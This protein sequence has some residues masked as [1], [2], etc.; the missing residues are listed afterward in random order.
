MSS[1]PWR[2][3]KVMSCFLNEITV[4]STVLAS[5]SHSSLLI[6]ATVLASIPFDR[7]SDER[8]RKSGKHFDHAGA[9]VQKHL[10]DD[11][12]NPAVRI[13]HRHGIRLAGTAE[14]GA[15]V[16]LLHQLPQ[17][18]VHDD[19]VFEPRSD[20]RAMARGGK[21]RSLSTQAEPPHFTSTR[22]LI[23][24]FVPTIVV[25]LIAATVGFSFWAPAGAAT[26][27]S[28]TGTVVA[29]SNSAPL[30]GIC[31][32][33]LQTGGQIGSGDAT[34]ASDG[35]YTVTGLPAG[36]Y[37]VSFTSDAGCGNT[38][39][40]EPQWYNEQSS[41]G[42][43]TPVTVTAGATTSNVNGSL[44]LVGTI[45]GT[46]TAAQGG[47]ALSGICV[48]ATESSGPG[49]GFTQ[50]ASDG[51]YSITGL[52]TGSYTVEFS[53]NGCGNSSN[54]LPQWYNGASSASAAT[55]V[56]V[57]AGSTTPSINAAMVAGGAIS[58]TVTASVG[59]AQIGGICVSVF[60]SGSTIGTATTTSNGSY[61]V[62]EL[63]S[64]SYTV[65]FA[66]GCG[67]VGSYLPQ[68]Y[69][70]QSSAGSANS[71]SVTD[72]STTSGI[73]GSLLPGGIVTG[74]VTAAVGGA[75]LQGICV[76]ASQTG[77]SG[78]GSA[79]TAANGTYTVDNLPTGTYTV[80]F[81]AGSCGNTG[82][83]AD[84]W[85]NSESSAAAANPVSVT[86]GSTT[87]SINAA[88]E[89]GATIEGTVTA[90]NGGADLSGIC[91]FAT[92]SGG[93]TPV[94]ASTGSNGAYSIT[95]LAAGSYTVEFT[96]ACG[97]SGSYADQWYNNAS[98]QSSATTVVV[99][100]GATATGINAAMVL[101]GSISGTVT[102]SGGG[103]LY[104]TCVTATE[105][106]GGAGYGSS[107]TSPSGAYTI[108]DLPA[109]TYTVDF[110]YCGSSGTYA[111]QWYNDES[112]SG[113]ANPVTVTAGA[114][115]PNI[116]AAMVLISLPGAPT[117]VAAT[118]AN[119]SAVV[120][121]AAPSSNGG[122]AISS[123]TVT[124]ADSTTPAT[125]AQTCTW[126]S[127]PLTCT[128][129][130]LTNGDSYTFTVTATNGVGT[131]PASAASELDHPD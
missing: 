78:T 122:S 19:V 3:I 34:T 84:Q 117:S 109:G 17:L 6:L 36:T 43:A 128:V 79:T 125:A 107:L 58:G 5:I 20:Q 4:S 62:G 81:S 18:D 63:P 65:E 104:L 86:A 28:I 103:G 97:N 113:A 8:L 54:L 50:T 114:T 12:G 56:A 108:G 68:W 45:T 130:G 66:P 37:T 124:A 55:G 35:T 131:G 111:E 92:I 11:R 110:Q 2:A 90:A 27:G 10:H 119:A 49:F 94:F 91:V 121:W 93:T 1:M 100:A 33:A 76:N 57:V 83:Y 51:T 29:A 67:D 61:T 15:H 7:T 80:E 30:G 31:V 96:A 85:Y 73:N 42:S 23:V 25:L 82:N 95:G 60:Q 38:T 9:R 118:A 75:D 40:Y 52:V 14:C 70:D 32:E 99:G 71:V 24:R 101:T 48:S 26:T 120:T 22:T 69:N 102:I 88:M 59:G 64:G 72:G 98:S 129:T 87:S 77:G 116:N 21:G 105:N 115:T 126:T 47:A 13:R 74:T 41:A 44:L 127:G 46:V 39:D 123:Y 53:V 106:G 16:A 112:S 89:P